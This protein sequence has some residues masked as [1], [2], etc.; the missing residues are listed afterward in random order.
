MYKH[1]CGN[2][3]FSAFIYIC[4][5][6]L[7]QNLPGVW[8]I[9]GLTVYVILHSRERM[10]GTVVASV[11]QHFSAAGEGDDQVFIQSSGRKSTV[12]NTEEEEEQL[13]T[14]YDVNKLH[15]QAA[16]CKQLL[17]LS[18]TFSTSTMRTEASLYDMSSS[19][20]LRMMI[21]PASIRNVYNKER[22]KKV[23]N[24]QGC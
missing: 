23:G 18:F 16:V 2:K 14:I 15:K 11:R 12:W 1:R 17:P 5:V 21:S 6:T 4:E 8:I 7:S 13:V 20:S 10:Y 9:S 22:D 19:S 24:R 3:Y